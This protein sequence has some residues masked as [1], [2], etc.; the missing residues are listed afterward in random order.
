[1]PFRHLDQDQL[2][3]PMLFYS[4]Q[5]THFCSKGISHA[6]Q[7]DCSCDP[8]AARNQ[9]LKAEVF[10]KKI[11]LGSD[12]TQKEIKEAIARAKKSIGR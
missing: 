6:D 11:R 2:L 5:T 10:A 8:C 9:A 7:C 12:E 4:N 3:P 1:M